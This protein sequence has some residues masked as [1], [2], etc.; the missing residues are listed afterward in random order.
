MGWQPVEP[1]L[2]GSEGRRLGSAQISRFVDPREKYPCV[3]SI[4]EDE[5]FPRA[6]DFRSV[7]ANENGGHLP[8][9]T[10]ASVNGGHLAK[11]TTGNENGVHLTKSGDGRRR[12]A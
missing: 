4:W 7:G 6:K 1:P 5:V 9:S 2:R 12:R 11:G 3:T 10:A 8:K